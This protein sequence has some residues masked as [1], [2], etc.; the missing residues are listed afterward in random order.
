[1]K[2]L[3][4]FIIFIL[5]LAIVVVVF[6]TTK[7]ADENITKTND[8][9]GVIEL[10]EDTDDDDIIS[11]QPIDEDRIIEDLITRSTVL[12][13][14]G[15]YSGAGTANLKTNGLDIYIHSV[16]A[17][18]ADPGDDKFYEGWL[19]GGIDPNSFVST[20]KLTKQDNYYVL[21]YERTELPEILLSYNKI[22]ITL[23]TTALGLDNNPELHVLEGEF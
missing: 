15:D 8:N 5:V 3:N 12:E 6:K 23:E 11:T 18:L 17:G 1:M 19:T 13:A 9:T 4:Y 7:D 16:R 14:V 21:S 20:G 22:V 10:L 2:N